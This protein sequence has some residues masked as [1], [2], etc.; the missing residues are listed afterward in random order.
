MGFYGF[1]GLFCFLIFRRN[2]VRLVFIRILVS[3]E[4]FCGG[5]EEF[6]M[7]YGLFRRFFI[8]FLSF[9]VVG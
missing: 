6:S 3:F 7:W 5:F 2:V 1:S 4:F 9:V 8:Y